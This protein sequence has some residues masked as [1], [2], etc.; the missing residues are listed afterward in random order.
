M[1]VNPNRY[2]LPSYGSEPPFKQGFESLQF[3]PVK[4]INSGFR[5]SLPSLY[6]EEGCCFLLEYNLV[7]V[8]DNALF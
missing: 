3:Y 1:T 6:D 7:S 8:L 4:R 2:E 5:R